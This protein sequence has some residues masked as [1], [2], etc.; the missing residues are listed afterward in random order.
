MSVRVHVRALARQNSLPVYNLG[1]DG[2]LNTKPGVLGQSAFTI[3]I[4][5]DNNRSKF[6]LEGNAIQSPKSGFSFTLC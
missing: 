2:N 1:P 3:P 6:V 4:T 5:E